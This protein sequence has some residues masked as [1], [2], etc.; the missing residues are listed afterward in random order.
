MNKKEVLALKESLSAE[1]LARIEGFFQSY[2]RFGWDEKKNKFAD[3]ENL[4][5][6]KAV[7]VELKKTYDKRKELESKAR[8][9]ELIEQAKWDKLEKLI[10]K[11]NDLGY[12]LDYI[13][14]QVN[15]II[16]QKHNDK[17]QQKIKE[18]QAQLIK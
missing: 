1:E 10:E 12:S 18:L 15:N 4:A 7:C 8:E 14:E 11:A 16:K 17:I 5:Q 3:C 2:E 13:I 9:K 6:V